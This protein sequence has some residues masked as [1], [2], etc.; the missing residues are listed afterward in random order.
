MQ[1]MGDIFVFVLFSRK[2]GQTVEVDDRE[3]CIYP[4]KKGKGVVVYISMLG[5]GAL[6]NRHDTT[7]CV[8]MAQ[9]TATGTALLLLLLLLLF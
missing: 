3:G 8:S 7:G 1:E 4:K 6:H 2:A 5:S 9:V